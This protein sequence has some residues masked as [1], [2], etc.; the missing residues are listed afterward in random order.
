M[1]KKTTIDDFPIF[2][3]MSNSIYRTLFNCHVGPEGISNEIPII[4]IISDYLSIYIYRNITIFIL[5]ILEYIRYMISLWLIYPQYISFP[6]ISMVKFPRLRP[7][8]FSPTSPARDARAHGPC[9]WAP[10]C[11]GHAPS[12]RFTRDN[13]TRLVLNT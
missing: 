13:P 5:V 10:R 4:T 2:F 3:P 8:A 11:K 1:K 12:W 9:L 7:K 6:H